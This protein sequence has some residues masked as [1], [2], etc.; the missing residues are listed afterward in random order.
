MMMVLMA[1]ILITYSSNI[2]HE[3]ISFGLISWDL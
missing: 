3:V 1:M 2:L